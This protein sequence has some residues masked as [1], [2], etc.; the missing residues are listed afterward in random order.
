MGW[1]FAVA[2]GLHRQSRSLV[3]VS[4][5]PIAAGHA[6]SIALVAGLLVATGLVAPQQDVRMGAGLLLLG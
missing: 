2:L 1:L 6:M 5:L 3:F 4:L